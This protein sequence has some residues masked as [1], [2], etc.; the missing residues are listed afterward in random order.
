MLKY[1]L[2]NKVNGYPDEGGIQ[3]PNCRITVAE[4]DDFFLVTML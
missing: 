4:I 1:Y 2:G 3:S